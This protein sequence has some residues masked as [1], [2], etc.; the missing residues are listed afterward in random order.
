MQSKDAST[1]LDDDALDKITA[2]EARYLTTEELNK[3]MLGIHAAWGETNPAPPSFEEMEKLR[4]A[5]AQVKFE[6]IPV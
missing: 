4:A 5:V 1:T 6:S 3:L 2:G